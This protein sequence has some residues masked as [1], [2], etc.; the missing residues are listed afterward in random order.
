M[1]LPDEH[2]LSA[3]L[4]GELPEEAKAEFEAMLR[5]DPALQAELEAMGGLSAAMKQHVKFEKELPHADFFLWIKLSAKK[6]KW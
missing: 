2:L 5:A 3:Y 1:K 4:D 6:L